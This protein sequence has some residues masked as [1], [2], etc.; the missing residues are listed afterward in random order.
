MPMGDEFS[1]EIRD[2][3]DRARD[4]HPVHLAAPV[5]CDPEAAE[6]TQA[7]AQWH[8]P[9]REGEPP[10]RAAGRD[11][12]D[13]VSAAIGEPQRAI[14][15]GHDAQSG[16]TGVGEGK[17]A[18]RPGLRDA[19]D[20]IA[21]FL[22][23]PERAIRPHRDASGCCIRGGEGDEVRRKRAY[24]WRGRGR[25][26]AGIRAPTA[27]GDEREEDAWQQARR[28][29]AHYVHRRA[30][31]APGTLR[32]AAVQGKIHIA[33]RHSEPLP[34]STPRRSHGCMVQHRA[35]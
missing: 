2:R 29:L 34:A 21:A 22:R 9:V 24:G 33:R 1:A 13:L 7:D 31:H 3:C 35:G 10:D 11:P 19:G 15:S 4:A 28:P 16:G 30:P 17:F 5:L 26:R 8:A 18:H 32:L 27:R 6:R 23:R 12:V 25:R 20:P 14:R